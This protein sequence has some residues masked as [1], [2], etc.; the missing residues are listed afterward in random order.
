ME[1]KMYKRV[2]VE[3]IHEVDGKMQP[4]EIDLLQ[5]MKTRP[6]GYGQGVFEAH[7]TAFLEQLGMVKPQ[8]VGMYRRL[9]EPPFIELEM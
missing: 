2:T 5:L 6:T 4:D 8:F 7:I 9:K 1:P 3:F